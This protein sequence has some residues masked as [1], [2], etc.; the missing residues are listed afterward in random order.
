MA[1]LVRSRLILTLACLVILGTYASVMD[2]KGISTD[3]GIRLAII[4]GGRPFTVTPP[5][6]P[7]TW[8]QVLQTGEPYAYQ[9]LYYLMQNSL[10]RL[11]GTQDAN[12][13]RAVNLG[14]LGVVLLGLLA[15]S[16]GW[17]LEARLLLLVVFSGNAYLLMHVLQI[18]E[19]IV[20][21]AWYVWSSWLVLRLDGR[22]LHRPWA[23][24]GWF[25]GYGLLLAAGFFLQSWVVF[26]AVAQ[27]AFL[28]LRR[29]Q[30][31]FRFYAHLALSYVV[32]LAVAWPYLQ[33]HRQRAD[34]GVWGTAGTALLPQ[35]SDGFHLVIS[36]HVARFSPFT[37]FLF[38]FWP[39]VVAATAVLLGARRAAD[40]PALEAGA[41]TRPAW[42][43]LLC[44]GAALAF[45]VAYFLKVD[46]LSV[47]PRYFVIHSF[48]LAWLLALAFR[49]LSELRTTATAPAGLRRGAGFALGALGALAL[50]TAIFQ[51][52]SFR[53]DP[54]LDTGLSPQDNWRTLAA[55]LD[56]VVQPGDT[57]LVS[58]IV[59]QATLTFTRPTD[60][61]VIVLAD[62]AARDLGPVRRL[63]YLEHAAGRDR[64]EAVAAQAAA[65]GLI[66][67]PEVGIPAPDGSHHLPAWRILVFARR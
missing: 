29:R 48:F 46:T 37:E 44:S 17:R 58:D 27:G 53:Q 20:G 40:A 23:D 35:L 16:R 9:P 34:V 59:Q 50:A 28:V 54:Y 67:G 43:M 36:G 55:G 64:R 26:P 51:V 8:D 12:F 15:L 19:Y 30:E 47:W 25:A 57:I 11:A 31:A 41:Y 6:E 7:P 66:E 13:F 2:L 45:Q 3:E 5:A 22:Q 33:A 42:L 14:F 32:V 52:R 61:P 60:L 49:Y 63:V 39:A 56:R 10:M 62:L 24:T 65:A 21:V 18:R 1:P 38:W 4:N